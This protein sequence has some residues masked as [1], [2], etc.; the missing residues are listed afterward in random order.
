[1]SLLIVI[2][3]A[4]NKKLRNLDPLHLGKEPEPKKKKKRTRTQEMNWAVSGPLK[5]TGSGLRRG[6]RQLSGQKG[7]ESWDPDGQRGL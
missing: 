6:G 2:G 7:K 1:M 5:R 4:R 3:A